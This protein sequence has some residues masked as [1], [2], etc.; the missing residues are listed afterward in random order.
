MHIEK[1]ME[2]N[3]TVKDGID[4]DTELIFTLKFKDLADFNDFRNELTKE[5]GTVQF[6][7]MWWLNWHMESWYIPSERFNRYPL[8]RLWPDTM[9]VHMKSYKMVSEG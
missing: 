8:G 3:Y 1:W 5:K 6:N 9:T 2:P 4:M 7:D